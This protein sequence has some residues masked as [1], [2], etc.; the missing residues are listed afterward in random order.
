LL[1][2]WECWQIWDPPA[3]HEYPAFDSTGTEVHVEFAPPLI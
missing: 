3:L 1:G 2:R